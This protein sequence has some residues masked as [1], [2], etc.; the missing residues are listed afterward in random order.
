MAGIRRRL[1]DE[2]R[3]RVTGL[4]GYTPAVFDTN[5]ETLDDTEVP[6][7]TVW[8]VSDVEGADSNKD[9]RH[10]EV[11][12]QL[13]LV[14]R[15]MSAI[16]AIDVLDEMLEELEGRMSLP[17]E[18]REF[19]GGD[20]RFGDQQDAKQ[21]YRSATLEYEYNYHAPPGNTLDDGA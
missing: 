20:V 15:K 17:F 5:A 1:R 12:I 4:G 7:A 16:A 8:I 19:F 11:T 6:A 14:S 2:L 9:E 21:P 10:H 18:G 13:T 3:T